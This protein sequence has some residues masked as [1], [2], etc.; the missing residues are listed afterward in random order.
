MRFR[1]PAIGSAL[2][3]LK[4]HAARPAAEIVVLL[5]RTGTI[6]PSWPRDRARIRVVDNDR[7]RNAEATGC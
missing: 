5:V 6:P 1:L 2:G 3:K 4:A 7:H